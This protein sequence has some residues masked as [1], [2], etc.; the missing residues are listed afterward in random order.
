MN[1][2]IKCL[3]VFILL[4]TIVISFNNNILADDPLVAVMP[5]EES[6]LGWSGFNDDDILDGITNDITN[7]LVKKEN[8]RVVERSRIKEVMKEQNL[9]LSGR[10]DSSTASKIGEILGVDKLIVGNLTRLNVEESS[11]ISVGPLSVSKLKAS[12]KIVG[13]IVDS[14]SAEI[15]ASFE[16]VGEKEESN[17]SIDELKGVSFGSKAFSKSALGK[18]IDQATTNFVNSIDV[19]KIT[20]TPQKEFAE[21]RVVKIMGDKLII[22]VGSKDAIQKGDIGEVIRLVEV[23]DLDEP[24]KMPIGQV[25]VFS[26]NN[27]NSSIVKIVETE[28]GENI[29]KDDIVRFKN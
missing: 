8:I 2:N 9:H 15:L 22:N 20:T 23:E 3:I 26:V 17:I 5:I 24:V 4:I 21:G 16:G 13:R 14:Q 1:K 7:K 18:G 25:K 19:E 6:D 10:I 27:E 28:D 11:G 12:V 29:K